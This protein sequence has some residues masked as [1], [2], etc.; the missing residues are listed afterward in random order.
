MILGITILVCAVAAR[1]LRIAAAILLLSCGILLGFVPALREVSLPPEIMLLL[2]LPALLYWESL[3]TSLRE[4]RSNLRVVVLASTVLVIATAFAVAAVAHA[5]GMAWGPAW[6]LGAAVAPTDATVIGV[7]ARAL[8]RRFMTTL[9]AESL[10]NDG[11]ALVIYGLAVGVTMGQEHLS[12]GHVSWLFLLA[13][14]GGAAAGFAVAWLVVLVRR[15]LDHP[16]HA[17][18]VSVVTPFAAFL[19]AETVHASG[20]LAVVVCG[21]T[22]SQYGPRVVRAETRQQARA[23]W[24]LTTFLLNS[25]L[26][27][28]IGLQAQTAIRGLAATDD[29][30]RA[31]AMTG[32]VA[33][34]VIGSRFAWM[35]TTPYLIRIL[36]R[37]PQQRL[38]R[39]SARQRLPLALAG[40]RG[41]VSLAAALSIPEAFPERDL[42]IVVT[43]G[44]IVITLVV[45]GLLLPAVV[46]WSHY[47][48]DEAL[49]KER[50][51]AEQTASEA[52]YAALRQVAD[53]LG[54]DEAA[55]ERTLSEYER[56]LEL[57]RK[58]GEEAVRE[59][60]VRAETDYA[61][62]RLELLA[63][64]RETVVRLRDE[65]KIDDTVLR[66]IQ[67]RL[68]VEE[69][70]LTQR[71]V[72]E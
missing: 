57:V 56:H 31:L 33:A 28:L 15:H 27:V 32:I 7:L 43:S 13:Y 1:R 65:Q 39:V 51:L 30:L 24:T 2:F 53:R 44:V 67:A 5:L 12:P 10:I 70:R 23:F 42:I 47:P 6:V 4:I 50:Q 68:D 61:A 17:N 58:D 36:D 18:L 3:T 60:A 20:V 52:A 19:L 9:R 11:T 35:Y 48:E 46:R 71:E 62:L 72:V 54:T 29:A 22:L 69:V 40:F 66:Q 14:A 34:T 38:R 64:K 16:L 49:V 41:A 8:P 25:A 26:F 59:A 45:Q 21:L 63:L 37:R 55:L